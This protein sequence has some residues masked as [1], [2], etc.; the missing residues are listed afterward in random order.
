M[1][2]FCS[3]CDFGYLNNLFSVRLLEVRYGVQI[4]DASL[5]LEAAKDG[6]GIALGRASLVQKELEQGSLVKL[7]DIELASSFSYF[8]VMPQRSI[9]HGAAQKFAEWLREECKSSYLD[10]TPESS[11]SD[12]LE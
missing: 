10:E 8:L 11:L 4:S 3:F 5:L 7:F 2:V 12:S 1:D 6:Q 9:N